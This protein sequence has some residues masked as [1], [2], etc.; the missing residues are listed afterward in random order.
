[1]PVGIFFHVLSELAADSGRTNIHH[2]IL[3]TSSVL[4]NTL[5]TESL[6]KKEHKQGIVDT[7]H[8]R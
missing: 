2:R 8:I 1:M 4:R 3:I 5:S 6:K 7:Q